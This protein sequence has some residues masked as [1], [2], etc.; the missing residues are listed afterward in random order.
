MPQWL[1]HT[2]FTGKWD[3]LMAHL[4]HTITEPTLFNS[5]PDTS[6]YTTHNQIVGTDVTKSLVTRTSLGYK[7]GEK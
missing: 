5:V 6:T 1:S 7:P 2:I 4:I 3:S